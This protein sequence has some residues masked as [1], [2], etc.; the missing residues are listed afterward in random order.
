MALIKRSSYSQVVPKGEEYLVEK[1][2]SHIYKNK[3]DILDMEDM[4]VMTGLSKKTFQRI[5]RNGKIIYFENGRKYYF[6]KTIFLKFVRSRRFIN[7]WSNSDE[8]IKI[9][10]DFKTW[11]NKH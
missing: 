10:E 6:Q 11:K 7:T 4:A 1:Y 8:F 2:F 5:V 9:L 3:P